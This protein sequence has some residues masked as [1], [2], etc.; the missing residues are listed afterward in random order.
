MLFRYR[1]RHFM[2]FCG[3]LLMTNVVVTAVTADEFYILG[4]GS[5][6]GSGRGGISGIRILQEVGGDAHDGGRGGAGGTTG[7]GIGDNTGIAGGSGATGSGGGVGA[8]NAPGADGVAS[9]GAAG[10][11]GGSLYD[12]MSGGG[13]GGGGV[14]MIAGSGGTYNLKSRLK[15]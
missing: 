10:G 4:G 8:A 6:A 7:A 9:N 15:L 13:G 5:G 3:I 12:Y 11:I 1:L 14:G 2:L